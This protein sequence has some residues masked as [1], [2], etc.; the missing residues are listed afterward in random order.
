[1]P[2]SKWRKKKKPT[3]LLNGQSVDQYPL[4]V[5]SEPLLYDKTVASK[6]C[7]LAKAIEIDLQSR[8]LHKRLYSFQWIK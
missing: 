5:P 7:R 6:S 3:G 4:R 1:M 2:F 8:T